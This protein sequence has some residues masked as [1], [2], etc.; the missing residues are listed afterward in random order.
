MSELAVDQVEKVIDLCESMLDKSYCIYSK[1]PVACV[2]ITDCGKL[3]T[4]KLSDQTGLDWG[5]SRIINVNQI[6]KAAMWR[7]LHL[8]SVFAPSELPRLRLSVRDI[9]SLR[10]VL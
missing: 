2:L 8:G 9:G 4:G 6:S 10:L 3:I 7:M 5:P 1:F